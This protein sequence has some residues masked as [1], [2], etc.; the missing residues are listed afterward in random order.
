MSEYMGPTWTPRTYRHASIAIAREYMQPHLLSQGGNRA[1]DLATAHGTNTARHRYA[2]VA[3][4]LPTLTNDAIG[5]FRDV[6]HAWHEICG[7]GRFGEPLLPIRL[8][9]SQDNQQAAVVAVA[10]ER[11]A[12]TAAACIGSI[13]TGIADLREDI[14]RAT[15]ALQ[16]SLSQQQAAFSE[17]HD[18]Q[19]RQIQSL[20]TE[21]HDLILHVLYTDPNAAGHDP[22]T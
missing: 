17:R 20:L 8:L 13:T 5:E 22:A 15:G 14:N 11:V 4:D 21:T 16:T 10:E 2:I 3:S 7:I 1:S 9:R 12:T 6:S 18:G 19:E